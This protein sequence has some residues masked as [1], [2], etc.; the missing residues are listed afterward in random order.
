[1]SQA[2]VLYDGGPSIVDVNN[3][4]RESIDVVDEFGWL[5][6]TNDALRDAFNLMRQSIR[7]RNLDHNS[8]MDNIA[9]LI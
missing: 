5:V 9:N 7:A 6:N 3:R 2:L 4:M 1:M 8:A